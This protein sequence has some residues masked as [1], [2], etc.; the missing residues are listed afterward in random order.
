M[1]RLFL[2][3]VLCGASTSAWAG[4]ARL[5]LLVA[6]EQG[7]TGEPR[8]K[9]A[10]QGDLL[11]MAQTM[12]RLGFRVQVVQ[13]P[14]AAY[15][16]EVLKQVV[17]YT[18]RRKIST[19]VFYYSG[20]AGRF[21]FHLGKRKKRPLQYQEFLQYFQKIQS[22]RRVAIFDSCYS[23]EIIRQF[24]SLQ[25]YRKLLQNGQLKGVRARRAFD[26]SN[27]KLPKKGDE[28][29][30][31]II[32]SSLGVAWEVHRYKASVFT[33]HFLKGL[34]GAADL[35]R[36]G[37]ITVDELFDYA[38]RSVQQETGQRPEQLI[39]MRRNTPYAF[40]P[41]YNSRLRIGSQIIGHL[42]ISV[43]NFVWSQHKSQRAPLKLAIVA[44]KGQVELKHKQR[45][46][47]QQISIPNRSEITLRNR[48]IA[49][50]CHRWSG[51]K[52][53]LIELPT[54]LRR[55]VPFKASFSI[56]AAGSLLSSA[57]AGTERLGGGSFVFH[58]MPKESLL[59]FGAR[60][61]FWGTSKV[62]SQQTLQQF[63]TELR[64][65]GGLHLKYLPLSL[66]LGGYVSGGLLFQDINAEA[67][68]TGTMMRYGGT[69]QLS[70]WFHSTI[71]LRASV[72][73]GASLS[74]RSQAWKHL[75]DWTMRLGF[76][77]HFQ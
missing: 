14:S 42:R 48:W 73:G 36:D 9:Y 63:Y 44:G 41:A 50:S 5:A 25:R 65:E 12:R 8:L 49:I 76:A 7:W 27:L 6:H 58:V 46:Y 68:R 20:H 35:D 60:L 47:R 53:G 38:S 75:P 77:Y 72:D 10:I 59:L 23:G 2:F 1:W 55:E 34:K 3:C 54:Q 39:L 61:G 37:K 40:A 56:G 62:F 29:G 33:Y 57:L 71:L 74:R 52:K 30:I 45:C 17:K 31:R 32:S 67:S 22:K 16:R 26:L 66:M 24:G 51:K 18:R 4:E 15:L 21:S 43:S 64:L 13:N 28:R 69:L 19:F 11:P 70:L